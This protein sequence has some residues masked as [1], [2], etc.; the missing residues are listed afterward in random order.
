[1]ALRRKH[2]RS[3]VES[4]LRE[5]SI[6]SA[7]VDVEKLASASGI[8]V[9]YEPAEDSL[10]GFLLRDP[11]QQKVI[12]GVNKNHPENRQRFTIGHELGHFLLHESGKFHVDYKFRLKIS[13]DETQREVS[14]EEKEANLFAAELLMPAKFI[15]RDLDKINSPDLFEALDIFEDEK[16]Q[17]LAKHYQVSVQALTFRLAYLNYIRL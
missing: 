5:Q 17:N 10:C 12:I 9:R 2:I 6:H 15:K 14:T 4:L 7:P 16:L 8:V 11:I 13:E 3:L 1:M